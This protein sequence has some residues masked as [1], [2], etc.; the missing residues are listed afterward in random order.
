MNQRYA[1]TVT[2]QTACTAAEVRAVIKRKL[3]DEAKIN[4][5]Q[6]W[7]LLFNIS[8]SAKYNFQQ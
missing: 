2:A 4:K 6:G 7:L 1:E 5:L 8:L 3:A